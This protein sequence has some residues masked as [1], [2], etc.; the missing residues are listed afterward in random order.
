MIDFSC[1]DSIA[2][3]NTKF[4]NIRMFKTLL[5]RWRHPEICKVL[6][7]PKT[8]KIPLILF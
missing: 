5:Q 3:P 8:F 6:I 7:I 2:P 1:L 4:R